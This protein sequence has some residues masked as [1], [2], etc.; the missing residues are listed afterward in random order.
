MSQSINSGKFQKGRVSEQ[1]GKTIRQ[2]TCVECGISFIRKTLI[3]N[4]VNAGKYAYSR[5]KYCEKHKYLSRWNSERAEQAGKKSQE[6]GSIEYLKKW[7]ED[8]GRSWNLGKKYGE[9]R[10]LPKC[11]DCQSQLG[12]YSLRCKPCAGKLRTGENNFNWKGDKYTSNYR[13]RRRFQKAIQKQVLTRDD[14]TCQMC[15]VKGGILHV[16]HIQSFAEYVELRFN[17]DNCRTLCRKCH[18][19]VTFNKVM[20]QDSTWGMVF[21]RGG[22]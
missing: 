19:L 13:E 17:M 8:G 3:K 5:V 9:G 10:K 16:D 7:R 21:K 20:P 18:Y 4:G 6:N 1:K 12:S 14:Y 15:K 22:E 2:N 11:I